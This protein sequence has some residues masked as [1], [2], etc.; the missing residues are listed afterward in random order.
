MNFAVNIEQ[1]KLIDGYD[2]YE[3][4][5]FGR[6]RN[7]ETSR[8]MKLNVAKAGYVQIDLCKD[9]KRKNHRVH[10]LVGFA[11]L[12]KKDG[13]IEVDHIDHNRSNNIITNLR[14]TTSSGNGRNASKRKDNSSG[15]QGVFFDKVNNRWFASWYEDKRKS[16]S[17]SV[18]Q[19]GNEE[20][21][22]RA[23]AYRKQKAEANGYLNV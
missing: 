18:D 10:R 14:W 16:K 3:V 13:D 4:S 17:F 20:A 6:V 9:G 22:Q 1:W 7:N 19:L 2:N 5:S 8:I 23:I 21:K 12:E 15:H 11:F